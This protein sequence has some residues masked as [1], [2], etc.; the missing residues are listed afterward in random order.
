M[1]RLFQSFNIVSLVTGRVSG[2]QK[3]CNYRVCQEVPF[4]SKW[5]LTI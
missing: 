4:W 3:T 2:L 1:T 5:T